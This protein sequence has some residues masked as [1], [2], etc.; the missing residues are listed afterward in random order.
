MFT[1]TVAGIG[2]PTIGRVAAGWSRHRHRRDGHRH[3]RDGHGTT[4]TATGSTGRA[5][6]LTAVPVPPSRRALAAGAELRPAQR[7][8]HGRQGRAG[9]RRRLHRLRRHPREYTGA[10][11]LQVGLAAI[12][13][14]HHRARAARHQDPGHPDDWAL[15]LILAATFQQ[16]I[17]L[18]LGITLSG[19]GGVLGINH[20][21]DS[22]VIAAGLR[23]KALDAILFPPDPVAQ[24]PHIFA[25]WSQTM[26]VSV[27]HT[28]VGR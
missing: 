9:R 4:G 15:L 11:Q 10:L 24:A 28:V 7:A 1:A 26:P 8:G 19:L 25:I 12:G 22:D 23:T 2:R 3:H 17:Q 5:P 20:A 27:G 14:R 21:I 18:G 6:A 13:R 16:G